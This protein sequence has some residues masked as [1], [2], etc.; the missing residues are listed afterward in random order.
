MAKATAVAMLAV[1]LAALLLGC[2]SQEKPQG[3]LHLAVVQNE[4]ELTGQVDPARQPKAEDKAIVNGTCSVGEAV[5]LPGNKYEWTV[6]FSGFA[7][8]N[9][10]TWTCGNETMRKEISSGPWKIP[11]VEALVCKLPPPGKGHINV[12]I[13]GVPCGQISTR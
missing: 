8:G 11:G 7:P 1:L 9:G 3:G 5:A 10:I 6:R 4:M 13:S 12:S 2:A